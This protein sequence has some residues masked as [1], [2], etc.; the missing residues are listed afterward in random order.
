M[1]APPI[2]FDLPPSPEPVEPPLSRLKWVWVMFII[3]FGLFVPVSLFSNESHAG[4]LQNPKELAEKQLQIK[5]ST[6]SAMGAPQSNSN[7]PLFQDD[8]EG[9]LQK[10]KTDTAAQKLRIALRREDNQKPFL[11]DIVHLSKSKNAESQA[12]AKLVGEPKLTKEQAMELLKQLDSKELPEKIIAVQV[13]ESFGDKK[14]R[15]ATFSPEVGIRL[16]VALGLMFGGMVLGT[17]AWVVYYSQRQRGLWPMRGFPVGDI[18]WGRADRL[19]FVGLVIFL[20][21]MASQVVFANFSKAFVSRFEL[22]VYAPIFVAIGIC[23]KV[24]IFGWRITPKMMGLSLKDFGQNVTWAFSAFFANIP[25][26]LSL[27]AVT[28]VLAKFL[29]GGSHPAAE[30]M[31]NHPS[32]GEI[33]KL[34][35]LACIIAPLWEEFFFRGLLF[36]AFTKA[37]GKP[38]YGA[39]LSSFL[40]ASIHPQGALGI[41]A[42]MGIAMMLC[43]VSYQTKSLV[44]NMILHGLHNGATLAAALLLAPLIN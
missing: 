7:P 18:D 20:T 31:L 40:F 14:V 42:L 44:G 26:M 15:A 3:F 23:L 27:L 24:P 30:D 11:D 38:I 17:I 13:K 22:L 35:F 5:L 28:E 33:A 32:F 37:L 6:K 43:A 34:A 36:P 21:F 25:I 8:I 9:L 16:S 1:Q 41:V 19:L 12:F 10:S 4:P 39:L 29:P 2:Q